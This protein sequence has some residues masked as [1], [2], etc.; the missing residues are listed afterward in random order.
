MLPVE[1]DGLEEHEEE[2]AEEDAAVMEVALDETVEGSA[3]EEK[4]FAEGSCRRRRILSRFKC[5]I[6]TRQKAD[7]KGGIGRN[8]S[9]SNLDSAVNEHC[10]ST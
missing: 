7:D 6:A 2:P 9:R 3:A 1:E 10:S 5:L 8:A 4:S